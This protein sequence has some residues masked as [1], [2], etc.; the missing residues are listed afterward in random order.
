SSASANEL[1][2]PAPAR[3]M[4]ARK[5]QSPLGGPRN[6]CEQPA[7]PPC[8]RSECA[9]GRA[10]AVRDKVQN[11]LW[12]GYYFLAGLLEAVVPAAAGGRGVGLGAVIEGLWSGGVVLGLAAPGGQ[13]RLLERATVGEAQLPGE[14][15]VD[16]VHRVEMGGGRDV[17]LTAGQKHDA[18]D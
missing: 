17:V 6:L 10:A 9:T 7:S 16:P 11:R 15:T 18:G 12:G 5:F 4:H 8:E 13:G 1:D 3:P 2:S 14:L